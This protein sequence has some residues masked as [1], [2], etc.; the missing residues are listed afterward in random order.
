MTFSTA[1]RTQIAVVAEGTKGTTPT[2]PVFDKLNYTGEDINY[3]VGTIQSDTIR[4][5]R[6]IADLVRT[7]VDVSGSI[8]AEIQAVA[9]EA[10]LASALQGAWSTPVAVSTGQLDVVAGT[11]TV[12]A[13]T[14]SSFDDAVA[15]Q[16]LKFANFVSAG[17]NGWH[18]IESVTSGVEIVLT[19]GSTALA[20][21]TLGSGGT[22]DGKYI[23]NGVTTSSYTIEKL[24][25][26][27][28][29]PTYFRFAGCEVSS[30]EMTFESGSILSAAFGFIGRSGDVSESGVAGATY[31]NPSTNALLD[32]V[33]SLGTI[34]ED[35]SASTSSFQSLS[36]SLDNNSRG[37]EAIGTLGY[38]GV[39]HGSVT[40]T[41][42]TVIYFESK[43]TFDKYV[44][45]TPFSISFILSSDDGD[46][47]VTIPQA[48]F[49]TMTVLSSAINTDVLANA[50]FTA[51]IDPATASMLQLDVA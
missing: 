23:R 47:V 41:G 27:S 22:I 39:A 24:L 51:I 14:A 37:Q 15:G 50:E 7:S 11:R 33:N 1:N 35:D 30:M 42:S 13:A 25:N 46:M 2:T 20:D 18:K 6:Q 28:T 10:L 16:W 45:G 12:T 4:A 48:K 32:S 29:V 3:N 40:I 43:S 19:T 26:D 34:R 9:F 5:D 38:V 8:N 21:E 49:S 31:N 44:A 17:N 36:L